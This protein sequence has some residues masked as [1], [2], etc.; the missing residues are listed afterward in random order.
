MSQKL[1]SVV[2]PVYNASKYLDE[3]VQSVLSQT[4][5]SFELIL[6]EDC[7]KD[8]SL[9]IARSYE[10]QDSRVRVIVCDRNHGVAMA[11]NIGVAEAKGDYIALMDSDDVWVESKLE[12]QIKLLESKPAEIVYCSYDFI[13]EGG[14]KKLKPFI[15]PRETN[16]KK[17]LTNNV[18]GCSMALVDSRLL[19]N[20][21]F[22][23]EFYHEDYVL[24]MELLQLPVKAVGEQRVL[25][26]YRQVSGSRSN[27]KI[28]AAKERWKTYLLKLSIYES[29]VAFVQYAINGIRKYY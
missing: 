16:Y 21:L 24:W 7:S 1:V 9:E 27:N 15:V 17:M 19:K 23:S 25:V 8:N 22:R 20:H 28:N 26:H 10:K 12:L 5:E 3:A 6:I 29:A 13:D 2:M 11:R 18:I 4:Y 14:N